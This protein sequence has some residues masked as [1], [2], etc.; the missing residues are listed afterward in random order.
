[1]CQQLLISWCWQYWR[2]EIEELK[3]SINT[4]EARLMYELLSWQYY[5]CCCCYCPTIFHV[6]ITNVFFLQALIWRRHISIRHERI[7]T[8]GAA[9]EDRRWTCPLEK[10]KKGLI[11]S[12]ICDTYI[13]ELVGIG[14]RGS[15]RFWFWIDGSQF[16]RG[17]DRV[18]WG[19]GFIPLKG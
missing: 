6:V 19:S 5:L 11:H 8:A 13:R 12:Y 10:G 7:E 18:F 9:V 14:D 16:W 3:R 4:L 2:S 1:M 17:Y 15:G